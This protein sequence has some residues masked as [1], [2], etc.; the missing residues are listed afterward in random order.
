MEA[1]HP[2]YPFLYPAHAAA[3]FVE[4]ASFCVRITR[5]DFAI[6]TDVLGPTSLNYDAQ[7]FSVAQAA[8][9]PRGRLLPCS[10][11]LHSAT[12]ILGSLLWLL[13][14][15]WIEQRLVLLVLSMRSRTLI[16]RNPGYYPALFLEPPPD[17][18]LTSE[19]KPAFQSSGGLICRGKPFQCESASSPTPPN[20]AAPL[21]L[22][23][24]SST[25]YIKMPV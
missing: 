15:Q 16:L 22:P 14:K 19:T 9:A 8:V 13:R 25:I 3:P 4:K 10:S 6:A 23:R 24:I 20:G 18:S 2:A 5:E 21:F 11:K 17:R 7:Q 1:P 12:S